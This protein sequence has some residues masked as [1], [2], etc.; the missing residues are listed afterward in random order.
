MKIVTI[1]EYSPITG[2]KYG[3][4]EIFIQEQEEEQEGQ[5]K[6]LNKIRLK[7]ANKEYKVLEELKA[8]KIIT[9]RTQ[10]K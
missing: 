5:E 6:E 4:K 3:E 8:K 2:V 10:H 9:Q 1:I 7:E